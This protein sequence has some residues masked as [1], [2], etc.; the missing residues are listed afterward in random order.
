MVLPFPQVIEVWKNKKH[1]LQKTV[2][3]QQGQPPAIQNQGDQPPVFCATTIQP[4]VRIQ[5]AVHSI[6]GEPRVE[7]NV[8][9]KT[10]VLLIEMLVEKMIVREHSLMRCVL[11]VSATFG[12]SLGTLKNQKCH[13]PVTSMF[14]CSNCDS[15]FPK[16][17][18]RCTECAKW[19]TLTEEQG[20]TSKKRSSS[21]TPVKTT[22][23][24][25]LKDV[26][27][28]NE[29]ERLPTGDPEINRVLGG[30]IVKGS[31][32]LISGE[33]GIGKSTIVAAIAGSIRDTV[34]YISGEESPGQLAARFHRIEK[35]TDHV[36][37]L[38]PLPV[39]LL[40]QTIEKEKPA[41]VIIDS[42]QT[43][44]S[45]ELDSTTGSPALVRYATALLLETAKRTGVSILLVGQVTKDGSIA[46]PK[47]LEHLVD[48]VI[49]IEGD[50]VHAYRMLRANKNRFGATDEIGVFEMTEKGLIAVENP[51]ARFLEERANTPGS[52]IAATIEGSRVFLVE[53][54]ALV[55]NSFYGT[56]VRR[57]SGFDQNRLQMLVAILS[58]RAGLK[59]GDKDV[60]VN[61]IGGMKLK[62]PAVDL[63]ICAA[64]KSAFTNQAN[65][66]PT[67]YIGEVGL[68]GE[69]RSA[70]LT[71]KRLTEAS[72]LG[73]ECAAIPTKADIKTEKIEVKRVSNIKEL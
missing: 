47:T 68:G 58:K 39:E 12:L 62:E 7:H 32:V 28:Q 55:E 33:P 11:R 73:I 15:Q 45:D 69:V 16:W 27:K 65:T 9:L 6:S 1:S 50:P 43:L 53:V 52:V 26:A 36:R 18:G 17:A 20:G 70:P 22:A 61:V 56:P 59:L 13:Q 31:L 67:V 63:A 37:I 23:S 41:L 49:E 24:Q 19:G 21:S 40:A 29:H 10:N 14:I 8:F 2:K 44:T 42:V 3:I 54:Q 66:T 25:P 72:R 5:Q 4:I 60:Y 46:G 51:S 30:G 64:I 71:Q 38:D 34:L 48:V 35:P 57:A